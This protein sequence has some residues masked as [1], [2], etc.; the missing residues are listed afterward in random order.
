MVE[1][2]VILGTKRE[3]SKCLEGVNFT[4]NLENR[5]SVNI[6]SMTEPVKLRNSF[7]FGQ[8]RTTPS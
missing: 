1:G 8:T 5:G 6:T 4:A 7:C 3:T 2:K